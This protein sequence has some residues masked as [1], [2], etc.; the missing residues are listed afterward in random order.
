MGDSE[1]SPRIANGGAAGGLKGADGN[2]TAGGSGGGGG[3]QSGGGSGTK[4]GALGI[5][6]DGGNG[7]GVRYEDAGGGGGYYGGGGGAHSGAGSRAGGGGGSSSIA[8][9]SG[10]NIS[11]NSMTF[12][13]C[14]MKSGTES[15]PN[16]AGGADM[17]GN[18]GNG[19][20]RITRIP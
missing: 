2:H 17:A 15:M 5:G 7:T 11:Y 3:T 1:R 13:E 20:A 8:G 6:G 12:S 10:C 18:S 16:P 9:M 14:V 4:P 19:Y